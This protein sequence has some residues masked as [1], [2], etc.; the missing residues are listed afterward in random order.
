MSET[1]EE[2][3]RQ[4]RR[5]WP[6]TNTRHLRQVRTAMAAAHAHDIPLYPKFR[7]CTAPSVREVRNVRFEGSRAAF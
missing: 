7:S 6:S 4:E 2:T 1:V 3:F 5:G